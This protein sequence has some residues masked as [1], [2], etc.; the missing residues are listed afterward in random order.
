MA[1]S[2]LEGARAFP[3]RSDAAVLAPSPDPNPAD[4]ADDDGNA[5]RLLADRWIAGLGVRPFRPTTDQLDWVWGGELDRGETRHS[6]AQVAGWRY[7]ELF[8][9]HVAEDVSVDGGTGAYVRVWLC[10]RRAFLES[11]DPAD[12]ESPTLGT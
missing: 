12:P 1:L 8:A 10:A 7:A 3:S 5:A 2:P 11:V 4:D 9:S 6:R